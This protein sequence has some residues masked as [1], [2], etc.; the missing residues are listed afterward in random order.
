MQ[1]DVDAEEKKH[2]FRNLFIRN[3]SKKFF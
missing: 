2:W 1:K 3:K